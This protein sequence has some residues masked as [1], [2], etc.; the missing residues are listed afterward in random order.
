VTN[1]LEYIEIYNGQDYYDDLSGYELAGDVEYTFPPG[2]VLPSGAFLVVARDPAGVVQ[3]HGL[4][5]VLGPYTNAL[6]NTRGTV[7][8]RNELG[9]ILLEV[10]YDSQAPWPVA[11]DGAGHSLVL[12]RP[13]YGE[14]DPG[15]GRR[16]NSSA[17]RRGGL[18]RTRTIR[19]GKW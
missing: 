14:G 3:V 15:P 10:T 5:G 12:A 6:P 13:S 18:S 1:S 17:A 16:A 11:P 4:S 8:L 9:A 2:T 7:R 19:C